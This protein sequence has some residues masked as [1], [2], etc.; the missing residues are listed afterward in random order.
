MQTYMETMELRARAVAAVEQT[1][2]E[3]PTK[4]VEG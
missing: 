3:E 4:V 2:L 1:A